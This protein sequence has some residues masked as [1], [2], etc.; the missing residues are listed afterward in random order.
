MKH[1]VHLFS[2]LYIS[3]QARGGDLDSFF[4]HENHAW[5][6]SLA[7]AN[8]MR[9]G[10][11]SELLPCLGALS[12]HP[13]ETPQVIAKIIDGAALI[14]S[15]NPQK[16]ALTIKTFDDYSKLVTIP[17]LMKQLQ[18]VKRVDVVWDI[19]KADSLKSSARLAR[20]TGVPIHING[21]TRIL[22]SWKSFLRGDSNKAALITFLTVA[23]NLTQIP[24]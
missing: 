7:K 18:T 14:H 24:E 20:G 22:Q 9:H 2:R 10:N 1:D 15:L 4:E 21:N 17:H 6:P 16:C 19:Y 3:C 11:K 13:V 5:P 12:L 23:I 8:E